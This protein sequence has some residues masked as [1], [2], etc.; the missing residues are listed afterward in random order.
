MI[1]ST[2]RNLAGLAAALAMLAL[3]SG[4]DHKNDAS[5]NP[6]DR[7]STSSAAASRPEVA[8][9]ATAASDHPAGASQ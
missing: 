4:C 9:P 2:T 6:G 3:T 5:G 1:S 8:S 7:T